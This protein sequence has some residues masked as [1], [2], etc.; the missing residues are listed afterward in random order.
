MLEESIIGLDRAAL[1]RFLGDPRTVIAFEAVL[2]TVQATPV[3]VNAAQSAAD[4][5]QTTAVA[6][7]ATADTI[8][9]S[10]LVTLGLSSALS[11]ERVLTGGPGVSLDVSVADIVK[12]VV[13]VI[14]ALGYT[15]A[16]L[17][18]ANFTGAVDVQAALRCDS[19]QIDQAAAASVAVV[20]RS[21]P[22]SLNGT[23]YYL[24][25]STTP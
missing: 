3:A 1:S 11:N 13:N 6:A 22:I 14:T 23:I 18:G 17:A 4:T 10:P 21:A 20:N 5:A 24:L 25:L 2:K 15:P 9:S 19:L 16:D 8:A 7:Q 12:I